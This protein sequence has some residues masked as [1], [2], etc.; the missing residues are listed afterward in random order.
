MKLIIVIITILKETVM[1]RFHNKKIS[2]VFIAGAH[3]TT[4]V[5]KSKSYAAET[6]GLHAYKIC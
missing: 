4:K 2:A 5:N 1:C 6:K 3:L